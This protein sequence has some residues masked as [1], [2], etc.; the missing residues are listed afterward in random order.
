MNPKNPSNSLRAW[1]GALALLGCA[2][3]FAAAGEGRSRNLLL[4]P[5]FEL[6]AGGLEYWRAQGGASAPTLRRWSQFRG[7]HLPRGAR[8][9]QPVGGLLLSGV[10]RYRLSAMFYTE[11]PTRGALTLEWQG[12]RRVVSRALGAG[13]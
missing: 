12:G 1:L 11:T 3:G 13:H 10:T 6:G 8:L 2:A 5:G 9:S 4:N 7:G